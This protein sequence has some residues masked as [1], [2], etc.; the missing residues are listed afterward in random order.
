MGT[1]AFADISYQQKH[2][3]FKR[4]LKKYMGFRL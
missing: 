4:N 1:H 3:I 2:V